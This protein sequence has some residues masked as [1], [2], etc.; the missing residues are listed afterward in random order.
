MIDIQLFN[1]LSYFINP[2][3]LGVILLQAADIVTTYYA[4]THG[5]WERNK[6]VAKIM[7]KLG[8]LPGLLVTKLPI[9]GAVIWFWQGI[10]SMW[11][12]FA[13]GVSLAIV[14]WNLNQIRKA[15]AR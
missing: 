11:Q 14:V 13:F 6:F 7:D 4:L 8:V 15:R 1:V 12:W 10:G 9:T 5:G 3:L 2:I